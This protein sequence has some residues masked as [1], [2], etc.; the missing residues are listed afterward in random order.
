MGFWWIFVK[1]KAPYCYA[2]ACGSILQVWLLNSVLLLVGSNR[3]ILLNLG[4]RGDGWV[5]KV[6]TTSLNVW[7]RDGLIP[8]R[9]CISL[10]LAGGV[11]SA[12]S[13][14]SEFAFFG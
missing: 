5:L 2:V 3:F 4:Y 6:A 11:G 7:R 12:G 9:C 10:C 13:K 14:R 1:D 8:F